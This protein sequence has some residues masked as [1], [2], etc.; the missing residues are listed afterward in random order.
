[1]EQLVMLH[2]RAVMNDDNAVR[3]DSLMDKLVRIMP[4]VVLDTS[5]SLRKELPVV[6]YV[7]TCLPM[8]LMQKTIYILL[9]LICE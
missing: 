2:S 4:S 5:V 6:L 7:R 3:D 8:L 1:M 9:V